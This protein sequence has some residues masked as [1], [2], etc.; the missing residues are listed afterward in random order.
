MGICDQMKERKKVWHCCNFEN[1]VNMH[2]RPVC[3]FVCLVVVLLHN[4]ILTCIYVDLSGTLCVSSV[5]VSAH[6]HIVAQ[7]IK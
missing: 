4:V 5:S 3:P 7:S 6:I 1:N 2:D